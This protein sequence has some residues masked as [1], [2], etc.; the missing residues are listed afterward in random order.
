MQQSRFFAQIIT[1]RIL[2]VVHSNGIGSVGGVGSVGR[3]GS[4]GKNI[5]SHHY[6]AGVPGFDFTW[7]C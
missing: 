7:G 6:Y 3:V 4:L 5:Y 1:K 2:V